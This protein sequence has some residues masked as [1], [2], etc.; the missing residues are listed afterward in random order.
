MKK[1]L[2]IVLISLLSVASLLSKANQYDLSLPLAFN[3]FQRI[4][5]SDN[6]PIMRKSSEGCGFGLTASHKINEKLC[7]QADLSYKHHSFDDFHDYYELIV[8]ARVKGFLFDWNKDKECTFYYS[9]GFGCTFVFRDDNDFGCY[10]I[11][12][13]GLNA[14]CVFSEKIS[15]KTGFDIG[16]SFQKGSRVNHFYPY[17]GCIYHLDLNEKDKQ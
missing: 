1:I 9:A 2:I 16:Y 12:L 13:A 8:D 15:V 6:N 11:V 7:A 3:S 10:P 17:I 5:Y 4:V 14:E